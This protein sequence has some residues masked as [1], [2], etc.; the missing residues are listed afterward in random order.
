M[1]KN[2]TSHAK[3]SNLSSSLVESKCDRPTSL[4]SAVGS[5]LGT[6]TSNPGHLGADFSVSLSDILAEGARMTDNE[7]IMGQRDSNPLVG[8]CASLLRSAWPA[9]YAY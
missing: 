5:M 4:P 3:S 7:N 6:G 2:I 8:T 1:F 9:H